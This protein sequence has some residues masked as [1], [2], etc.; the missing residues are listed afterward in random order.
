[1]NRATALAQRLLELGDNN[2]SILR[3][4]LAHPLARQDL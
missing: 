4:G 2:V 3:G 1:M